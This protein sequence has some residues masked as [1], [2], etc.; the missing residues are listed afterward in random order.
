MDY[1]YCLG[2]TCKVAIY[3]LIRVTEA[4]LT[5]RKHIIQLICVM[6]PAKEKKQK[7]SAAAHLRETSG[8]G[9]GKKDAG[10]E[11]RTRM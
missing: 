5:I 10:Q 1:S 6:V 4:T 8:K 7:A 2:Q 3:H 11:R 9:C